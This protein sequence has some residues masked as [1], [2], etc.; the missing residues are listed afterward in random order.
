M[1][2]D[3]YLPWRD[4]VSPVAKFIMMLPVMPSP[5]KQPLPD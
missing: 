1:M 2:M 4:L 5:A 3:L